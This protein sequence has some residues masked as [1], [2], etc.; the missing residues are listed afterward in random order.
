LFDGSVARRPL[1]NSESDEV[2]LEFIGIPPSKAYVTVA[3]SILRAV[4]QR[5]SRP[6]TS[7]GAYSIRLRRDPQLAKLGG[8]LALCGPTFADQRLRDWIKVDPHGTSV[9]TRR[10]T[11][12][13]RRT[14]PPGSDVTPHVLKHTCATLMLQAGIST[15]D[16]AGVLGTSEAVIRKTYGHHSVE[17]LRRAVRVWSK[18]VARG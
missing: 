2:R 9:P 8:Q 3:E 6:S 5:Q 4:H 11:W 7:T 16:V 12:R 18:R 14:P 15:W 10:P 13:R 1:E 17:H